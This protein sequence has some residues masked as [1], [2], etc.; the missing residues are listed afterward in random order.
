VVVE[1]SGTQD[2]LDAATV[3]VREHGVISVLGYH[4]GGRRS[5][6]LQTWNWKAID[7]VNAHVRDR[8][9]LTDAI[10][11]RL[12]LVRTG[13]IRPGALLTHR[14]PLRDVDLAFEALASKPSGFI[15]A[16]VVNEG[17]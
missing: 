2:G 9:L 14:F 11:E 16:I 10:G 7:V 5:V 6:D 15:K 12:E 8:G 3:L 4:Q 17:G 1:A 13:R